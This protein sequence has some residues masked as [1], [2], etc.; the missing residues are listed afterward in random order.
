MKFR[1]WEPEVGSLDNSCTP[2]PW[3][4][5]LYMKYIYF[6][7]SRSQLSSFSWLLPWIVVS[8]ISTTTS[9]KAF[10]LLH[11]ICNFSSI[12][13]NLRIAHLGIGYLVG[14]PEVGNSEYISHQDWPP[15]LYFIIIFT[16]CAW[17]RVVS[18]DSMFIKMF[19]PQS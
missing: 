13:G 4:Y 5:K 9:K 10:L 17:F 1:N 16:L 6:H 12:L 19:S 14:N 7:I 18:I 8:V 2:L 11:N 3:K 15:Q